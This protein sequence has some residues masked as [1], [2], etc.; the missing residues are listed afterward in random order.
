MM[1]FEPEQEE[2]CEH[3][4][5]E[6]VASPVGAWGGTTGQIGGRGAFEAAWN[7]NLHLLLAEP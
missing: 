4:L 1:I 7:L 3:R 5:S 6:V 2:G